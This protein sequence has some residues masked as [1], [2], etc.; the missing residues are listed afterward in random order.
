MEP[1][2]K[3]DAM[4][5]IPPINEILNTDVVKTLINCH[6]RQLILSAIKEVIELY[7]ICNLGWDGQN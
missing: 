4:R 1:L 6:S 7:R 2:N 3:Q 5:A